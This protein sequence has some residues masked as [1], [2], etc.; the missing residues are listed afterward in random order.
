MDS[1]Q[2]GLSHI[3]GVVGSCLFIGFL[4]KYE[5]SHPFLL[6]YDSYIMYRVFFGHCLMSN[7]MKYAHEKLHLVC[8]TTISV[9]DT[10]LAM[11]SISGQTYV[12]SNPNN[13]CVRFTYV[14]GH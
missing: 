13:R 8:P 10:V 2:N 6:K 12:G 9:N 11:L 1:R 7:N 5:F 3:D 14:S 4:S